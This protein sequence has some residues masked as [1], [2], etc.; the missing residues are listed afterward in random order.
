MAIKRP[1]QRHSR[2]FAEA[3]QARG[4]L[5]KLVVAEAYN[6]FEVLESFADPYGIIGYEAL[7]QMKLTV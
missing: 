5:D 1:F 3:V 7:R 4:M 6:H 2:E